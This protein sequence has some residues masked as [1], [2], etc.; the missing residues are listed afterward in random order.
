VA[1]SRAPQDGD[2][3]LR[4]RDEGGAINAGI[5]FVSGS[6]RGSGMGT[7]LFVPDA[8]LHSVSYFGTANTPAASV[9]AA[10]YTFETP[11]ELASGTADGR[12]VYGSAAGDSAECAEAGWLLTVEPSLPGS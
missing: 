2:L 10:V 4:F 1:R 9:R 11:T 7:D 6:I 5:L 3:E 8:G 12:I